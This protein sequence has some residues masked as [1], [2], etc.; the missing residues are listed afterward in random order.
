MRGLW[1]SSPLFGWAW[2]C[3]SA[4]SGEQGC[5][6]GEQI[7]SLRHDAEERDGVSKWGWLQHDGRGFGVQSIIDRKMRVNFTT[8]F[9]QPRDAA[10]KEIKDRWVVRIEGQPVAASA[11]G[12]GS[13]QRQQSVSLFFYTALADEAHRM[14]LLHAAEAAASAEGGGELVQRL[15]AGPEGGE[16]IVRSGLAPGS[17]PPTSLRTYF[18]ALHIDTSVPP[19]PRGNQPPQPQQFTW[20]AKEILQRTLTESYRPEWMSYSQR[21]QAAQTAHQKKYAGK[22]PSQVPPFSPPAEPHF[23]P[24]LPNRIESPAANF[25]VVQRVVSLPFTMDFVMAPAQADEEASA[26][27]TIEA[28]AEG[29]RSGTGADATAS[30]NE[31]GATERWFAEEARAAS[32]PVP[33]SLAEVFAQRSREF[34]ARFAATFPLSPLPSSTAA[35]AVAASKPS[36]SDPVATPAAQKELA[37]ALLSNLVG[38]L[39][40]F[41]GRQIIEE[42]PETRGRN[43]EVR[44]AVLRES[45]ESSLFSCVP[46]RS[47]FPRGFMWDEGFHQL[48]V[49][50]WDLDL[51]LRVLDSWFAQIRARP[52]GAAGS[53]AVAG[54]LPREQILGEEAR[55]RVPAEFRAQKPAVANPPTMILALSRILLR[56]RA[57]EDEER[58]TGNGAISASTQRDLSAFSAFLSKWIP[59]LHTHVGWFF[60]TQASLASG[61]KPADIEHI[62]LYAPAA[63]ADTDAGATA[64][65][66]ASGKS[67]SLPDVFRWAGRTL[68]HCLPSGLDDYPRASFLP[69]L[70]RDKLSVASATQQNL[71]ASLG[72]DAAEVARNMGAEGH[73]DLQS[74][75]IL[76]A[77][78][79]AGLIE[80]A[81]S[82]AEQHAQKS[83][84]ASAAAT[85]AAEQHAQKQPA[86]AAA[87]APAPI[88][89]ASAAHRY[90]AYA[91]RL[92]RSLHSFFW[93]PAMAQGGSFGDFAYRNGSRKGVEHVGYVSLMPLLLRVLPPDSPQLTSMLRSLTEDRWG[94]LSPGGLRSLSKSDKLFGAGEDYWRGHVWINMQY[95]AFES[96]REYARDTASST[97]VK[98][99][100]RELATTLQERVTGNVLREYQRT[101]FV[102]EQYHAVDGKGRKSHPFTGWTAL[103][104]LLMTQQ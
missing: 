17:P 41:H 40:F 69:D 104:L 81:G 14:E 88:N 53:G 35:S 63:G 8:R 62:D 44:A 16:I 2:S 98:Q 70:K 25:L 51:S 57:R 103:T 19:K 50:K 85:P 13:K 49:S 74:W 11:S 96:L 64:K 23:I 55:K 76:L 68:A 90:R 54:W 10:G 94:L 101:G 30:R 91:T 71:D 84:V 100:A 18:H 99:L 83:V 12:D 59:T 58:R 26:E 82:H 73:V 61:A 48:L 86:A 33:Q 45:S 39:G 60:R 72:E 27:A 24:V 31:I 36:P 21:A 38:G 89:F 42:S 77:D 37:Q 65:P 15:S 46:S 52:V 4:G 28:V 56:L 78:T 47:F 66:A 80:Y 43:G 93:H 29:G 3:A 6:A 9:V 102:W 20:A 87:A 92:R 22:P 1:G 75:M 34:D 79:M 5:G 97:E 32:R 7:Q 95:L 67:V